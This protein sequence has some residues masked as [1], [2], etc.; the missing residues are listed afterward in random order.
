[1]ENKT[2]NFHIFRYHLLPIE[3][4]QV[5]LF[6]KKEKLTYEEVKERK[7]GFFKEILDNLPFSKSNKNPLVLENTEDDYYLFKLAQK[8]STIITQNFKNVEIDNEP[9]VYVIVNNNPKIQKIAISDNY[10][11]FSNP[12]VVK[13][14]LKKTF[15]K[16]LKKHRLNVEIE[17]LFDKI[18]FWDYV[19]KH[20]EKITYI[21][22]QFIKPNLAD[23][24][25][26]LPNVFRNFSETVNSHE[27]NIVLKAPEK[28]A[29]ENISQKNSDIKGL[30]DYSSEGAGNIRLKVKKIRKQLNTQDKPVIL[31]IQE[32]DLEGPAEQVI[33][34][35]KTIVE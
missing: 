11:A 4:F 26:S 21:N 13:N 28:G 24:S 10:E 27:S 29:L 7:N 22:F 6:E 23:I 20:Q 34:L 16:D 9:Y 15:N 32:L 12:K 35:Y 31:E 5:D 18:E 17:Q 30:V 8:K 33:K 19:K 3:N 2:V 14:L 25:K 1:M